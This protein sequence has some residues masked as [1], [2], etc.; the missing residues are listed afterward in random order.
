VQGSAHTI[1]VV[2]DE[3]TI[4]ESLTDVLSYEGYKVASAP[5]GAKALAAMEEARPSLILVDFMMPVLDGV[6]F[7]RKV[8]ADERYKNVPII[9]MTAAPAGLP[10]EDRPWNALLVKPFELDRLLTTIRNLLP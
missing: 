6:Q 7:I 9:M 4:V 5:N 8:R 10:K 2:D 3:F 1:L